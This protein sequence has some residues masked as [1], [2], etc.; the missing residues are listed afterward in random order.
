MAQVGFT[1]LRNNLATHLD[2]V[3]Q[4]RVELVVTRQNHEDMVILPRAEWEGLRET[5]HLLGTPANARRLI[6][7]I[8]ELD[9][10]KG[11]SHDLIEP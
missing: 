4:D 8:S 2:R 10:G 5:M 3:E 11:T 6:D 1:E 9:A 7:S